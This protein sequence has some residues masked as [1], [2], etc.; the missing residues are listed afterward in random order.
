MRIIK[1]IEKSIWQEFLEKNAGSSGTEFLLSPEWS[2]GIEKDGKVALSLFVAKDFDYSQKELLSDDILAAIVLIKKTVARR[3]FYWYAPRGPLLRQGLSDKRQ[4]EVVKFL[5][6]AISRLDRKAL[7]LKLE[8]A[9]RGKIFWHKTWAKLFHFALWRV[10]MVEAVQPQKTVVLDLC[11]EEEEL[12]KSFH[13]KTR[14][15]IRL[16][17]KKGVKIEEGKSKDFPAFWSLM[18]KTA[19]RDGFRI[20]NK[21]HYENLL[22]LDNNFIKLFLASYQEKVIAAA[23]VSFYGNRATYL[24]GASDNKW[25]N[26]MAPHLLQ[27]EVIKVAKKRGCKLYDFYGIDEKKWPGVTR[28]KLG[29]SKK[30][31]SYAGTYDIIFRS[32]I[33][34]MYGLIKNGRALIKIIGKK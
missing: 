21:G 34:R 17:V 29:F 27:W 28:F 6:K 23:F 1:T 4:Q 10:K 30:I 26:L 25:R 32:V 2:A 8:P 14:Y 31:I 15:N 33:Y 5:I 12:L 3:F 24:H 13:Q 16:A 18:E 20:H 19:Q 9:N 7:F 22:N 11:P